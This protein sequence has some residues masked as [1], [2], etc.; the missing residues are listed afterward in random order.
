MATLQATK[1]EVRERDGQECV[2]CGMTQEEHQE[3][4]DQQLHVHHI[5]PQRANGGDKKR[6]LITVCWGCH[7]Q[8]EYTQGKAIKLLRSELAQ[9]SVDKID[10]QNDETDPTDTKAVVQKGKHYNHDRYGRVLVRGFD[11]EVTGACV[12]GL[13]REI[14][15]QFQQADS[16]VEYA[17]P[18]EEFSRYVDDGHKKPSEV[19]VD[20]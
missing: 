13:I 16:A 5:I 12:D 10:E 7:K 9:A 17:E 15:V 3:E 18:I 20:E 11:T 14:V 8:L 4:H 6:N 2:F 19:F 1:H